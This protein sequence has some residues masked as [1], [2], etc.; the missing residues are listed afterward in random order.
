MKKQKLLFVSMVFVL[1][2]ALLIGAFAVEAEPEYVTWYVTDTANA[3]EGKYETLQDAVRAAAG[4]ND[5]KENDALAIKIEAVDEQSLTVQNGV[6]FG[7]NTITT[8]EGNKLPITIS[9]G[10]LALDSEEDAVS[11]TNDYS[12][13]NCSMNL[14]DE[15]VDFYAGA[16]FVT[17][18]HVNFGDT[19]AKLWADPTATVSLAEG[20]RIGLCLSETECG[21]LGFGGPLANGENEANLVLSSAYVDEV[22]FCTTGHS[23]A[24]VALTVD[25][26]ST[27]DSVLGVADGQTVKGD[28]T[29]S[30]SGGS[31]VLNL[32][33]VNGGTVMGNLFVNV[34]DGSVESLVAATSD[35]TVKGEAN[36]TVSGGTL[37]TVMGSGAASSN[38]FRLTGGT[39]HAFY[40]AAN[41]KGAVNNEIV[42]G[43]VTDF[44]GTAEEARITNLNNTVSGGVI[45]A[46]Y[47]AAPDAQV[48]NLKNNLTGGTVTTFYGAGGTAQ[49]VTNLVSGT[50]AVTTFYGSGNGTCGTV[51]TTLNGTA[52]VTTFYGV[53]GAAATV[54][55]NM[56]D[57]GAATIETFRGT[58]DAKVGNVN[59]TIAGG[60]I[61][62]DFYGAKGAADSVTNTFGVSNQHIVFGTGNNYANISCYIKG[63]AYG[64]GAGAVST[65]VNHLYTNIFKQTSVTTLAEA[66]FYGTGNGVVGTV[67]NNFEVEVQGKAQVFAGTSNA[68][69]ADVTGSVTNTNNRVLRFFNAYALYPI[70]SSITG[71]LVNNFDFDTTGKNSSRTLPQIDTPGPATTVKSIQNIMKNIRSFGGAVDLS[72]AVVE[73][74]NSEISMTTDAKRTA[75]QNAMRIG[76]TIGGNLTNKMSNIAFYSTGHQRGVYAAVEGDVKNI[77]QSVSVV[78]ASTV[79]DNGFYLAA[80]V[81]GGTVT[82]TL[83]N[84]YCDTAN[85]LCG[86]TA[87]VGSKLSDDYT[88]DAVSTTMTR[89]GTVNIS[90]KGGTPA[91]GT[92]IIKTDFYGS[93]ANVNG[94]VSNTLTDCVFDKNVIAI[95]GNCES[96]VTRIQGDNTTITG[97]LAAWNE[98]AGVETNEIYLEG[99]IYLGGTAWVADGKEVPETPLSKIYLAGD[100]TIGTDTILNVTDVSDDVASVTVT[101]NGAWKNGH[102][103]VKYLSKEMLSK[104]TIKDGTSGGAWGKRDSVIVG[105]N[106]NEQKHLNL[107][108]T[109]RITLNVWLEAAA[110]DALL[111]REAESTLNFEGTLEGEILKKYTLSSEAL[112]EFKN[113]KVGCYEEGK[114]YVLPVSYVAAHNFDKEIGLSGTV[115][116]IP[117]D[118]EQ[119]GTD[120]E[121]SPLPVTLLNLAEKGIKD[122]EEDP[123]YVNLFTAL[124]NY[125]AARCAQALLPM[126]EGFGEDASV[127]MPSY[128]LNSGDIQFESMA[129][130][131]GDAIGLRFAGTIRKENPTVKLKV[132]G[133]YSNLFTKTVEGNEISIDV[134]VNMEKVAEPIAFVFEDNDTVLFQM[135]VSVQNYAQ[136]AA[137]ENKENEDPVERDSTLAL[138]QLSQAIVDY[139]AEATKAG[140]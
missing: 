46:F 68:A 45:K 55:N 108:V 26:R 90:E 115:C 110:V 9:G 19:A 97:N 18:S 8:K 27:V 20:D 15:S 38:T 131:M 139:I 65:V 94:S 67:I 43:T 22:L 117:F 75:H 58:G 130:L 83:E 129:L 78:D 11:C 53:C 118:F 47:G 137:L 120:K 39:V 89:S 92:P 128:T 33:P 122:Y 44:Y 79:A 105:V 37:D 109:E 17:F 63:V 87:S 34:S 66:C 29:V 125:G 30:V 12:F 41:C 138:A 73:N 51:S 98:G 99:G 54:T 49:N 69:G 103:Y 70:G 61:T 93:A 91:A 104:V 126:E 7:V 36:I 52:T 77:I 95:N 72:Y 50:A 132:N 96:A 85:P 81:V 76:G 106:L 74:V 1:L 88:G 13:E 112:S 28:L 123:V 134:Y 136:Y 82:N 2:C 140:A 133:E 10:S 135:T 127:Q 5:W 42:D 31:T 16:G 3:E 48:T 102:E 6:L 56:S 107:T 86:A 62:G 35:S 59:N 4:K 80:R 116:G 114:Y 121:G 24:S 21:S 60:I 84:F 23:A 25:G 64:T 111:A 101:Q 40:G 32:T 119:I 71:S 124:Y 113:K 100:I 57:G 14:G